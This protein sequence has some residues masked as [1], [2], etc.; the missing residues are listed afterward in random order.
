MENRSTDLAFYLP[1]SHA[2]SQDWTI[3]RSFQ[4][5]FS[6]MQHGCRCSDDP[7]EYSQAKVLY[8]RW[9]RWVELGVFEQI[10]A[11]LS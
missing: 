6:C 9:K 8:D 3:A 7:A 5:L 1:I 11:M 4:V 2:V 10:Y